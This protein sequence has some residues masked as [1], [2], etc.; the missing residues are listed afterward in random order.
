M[1]FIGSLIFCLL[2]LC[3]GFS[4]KILADSSYRLD[5]KVQSLD[6]LDS[7]DSQ[8]NRQDYQ[9]YPVT[10][11]EVTSVSKVLR[12]KKVKTF[13][14][15]GQGKLQ[16]S[17][18][19]KDRYKPRYIKISYSIF[20]K[21]PRSKA[22][23]EFLLDLKSRQVSYLTSGGPGGDCSNLIT[24]ENSEQTNLIRLSIKPVN[25]Y[26]A[27]QR[28]S[29]IDNVEA[30]SRRN[31]NYRDRNSFLPEQDFVLGK[32]FDQQFLKT[33]SRTNPILK[34]R[35]VN[36]YI[37][38]LTN[39]IV[40]ASD[41]PNY[42]VKVRVIDADLLNAFAVPGG[43]IYI[44]RGLI[45]QSS[46]EAELAGVIAHELAHI[47]A[48]HGTEGMTQNAPKAGFAQASAGIIETVA[49]QT[50]AP[51]VGLAGKAIGL[52]IN[53]GVKAWIAKSSRKFEREADYLATQYLYRAG[54]SP[55]E[56]SEFF[57][58]LQ[59]KKGNE[60]TSGLRLEG[61]FA[62]H[63]SDQERI[64]NILAACNNFLPPERAGRE[65]KKNS[66]AYFSVK[67]SLKKLP[68]SRSSSGRV[69]SE[70]LLFLINQL[71]VPA[72]I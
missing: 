52:G 60:A 48:R 55:Q 30:V 5:V 41:Y 38:D 8:E 53:T 67:N 56:F 62:S 36:E 49:N 57:K 46:S 50:G 1:K 20:N 23:K 11:V 3:L 4:Q 68:R 44:Y 12:R 25:S 63:P 51:L 19:L 13:L 61:F 27:C 33:Q 70:S 34:D 37:Q 22:K 40:K 31:I 2:I 14:T 72:Q 45:E 65:L 6:S 9:R 54:Y 59:Q 16:E 7:L 29:A 42:P 26:L 21:P 66:P 24:L 35:N 58:T 64:S 71:G 17:F 47:L 10:K 69:S 28:V 32:R 18:A 15:N 43:Y 39:K